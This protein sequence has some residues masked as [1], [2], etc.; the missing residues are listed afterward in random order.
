MIWALNKERLINSGF[1]DLATAYQ[2][3]HIQLQIFR[4]NTVDADL[5]FCRLVETRNRIFKKYADLHVILNDIR[6]YSFCMVCKFWIAFPFLIRELSGH[7]I[8][9]FPG[10]CRNNRRFVIFFR[11]THPSF[12]SYGT[13]HITWF[14]YSR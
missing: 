3:V 6:N 1:Y 14:L 7:R 12:S 11:N 4:R 9:C 10:I 8:L 13:W 5:A 2:S